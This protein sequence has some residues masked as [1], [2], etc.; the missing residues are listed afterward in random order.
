M[1]KRKQRIDFLKVWAY[2]SF[3]ITNARTIRNRLHKG[4][5]KLME[6]LDGEGINRSLFLKKSNRNTILVDR[7]KYNGDIHFYF[8]R[9]GKKNGIR[10]RVD[11]KKLLH[12][13]KTGVDLKEK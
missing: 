12:W 5:L 9:Y 4:V 7:S 10:K 1:S 8:V 11:A 2:G 6:E 3:A 13:V